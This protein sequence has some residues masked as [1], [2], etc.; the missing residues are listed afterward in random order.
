MAVSVAQPVLRARLTVNCV[1]GRGMSSLTWGFAEVLICSGGSRFFLVWAGLC[2]GDDSTSISLEKIDVYALVRLSGD[3][4]NPFLRRT[5]WVEN[6]R[7]TRPSS[8][9]N[10]P[11]RTQ[12]PLQTVLGEHRPCDAGAL[13][14]FCLCS[15]A[16]VSVASFR[17][18][19]C[20]TIT[21]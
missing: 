16:F 15:R 1:V 21:R 3:S 9:E 13:S 7:V 12:Q 19:V 10:A 11:A 17:T 2:F 14:G 4:S 6:L 20:C 5:P 18:L 8:W